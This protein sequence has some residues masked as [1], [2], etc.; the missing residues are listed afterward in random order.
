MVRLMRG[1]KTMEEVRLKEA[2]SL[3]VSKQ[4]R[5]SGRSG[6]GIVGRWLLRLI[7]SLADMRHQRCA[8]KKDSGH[9]KTQVSDHLIWGLRYLSS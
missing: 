1:M 2:R 5:W 4:A 8:V 6:N 9:R 7:S 3:S